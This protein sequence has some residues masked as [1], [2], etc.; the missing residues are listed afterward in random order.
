[1]NAQVSQLSLYDIA[2]TPGVAAD[3]SHI[4]TKAQVKV[5]SLDVC[6]G[7]SVGGSS[8][9]PRSIGFLYQPLLLHVPRRATTRMVS[10]RRCAVATW[11]S[12]LPVFLAS[13]A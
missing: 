10:L 13:P 1:M 9:G 3:V 6:D 12:F 11:S 5:S 2:G 4:N 8:P 7:F